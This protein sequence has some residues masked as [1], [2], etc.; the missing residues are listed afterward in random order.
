MPYPKKRKGNPFKIGTKE[1]KLW[2]SAQRNK[3]LEF[4]SLNTIG[5][6]SKTNYDWAKLGSKNIPKTLSTVEDKPVLNNNLMPLFALS[7]I[8]YLIK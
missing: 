5:G 8:W 2:T 3:S 1:W 6:F 4:D 7:A